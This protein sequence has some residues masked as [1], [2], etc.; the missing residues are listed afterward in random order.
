MGEHDVSIVGI[1]HS[2]EHG[3][4]P[5]EPVCVHAAPRSVH[6]LIHADIAKDAIDGVHR[7][8]GGN[9]SP[10]AASTRAESFAVGPALVRWLQPRGSTRRG[11]VPSSARA[12]GCSRA[13]SPLALVG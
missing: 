3:M 7:T 12:E 8:Q 6:G 5:G 2:D 11:V 4:V 9:N 10:W 1:G 13:M